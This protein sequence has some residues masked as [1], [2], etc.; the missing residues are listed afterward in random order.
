MPHYF[1]ELIVEHSHDTRPE[2]GRG[3]ESIVDLKPCVVNRESTCER[4]SLPQM[5][6]RQHLVDTG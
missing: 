4:C 5:E 1:T 6:L 3:L 2:P